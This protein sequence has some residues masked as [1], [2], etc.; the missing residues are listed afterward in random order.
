MRWFNKGSNLAV[1]MPNS[2]W[3][4][5]IKSCDKHFPNECGGILIGNY[6]EALN[7]AI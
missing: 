7:T 2:V 6:D 3:N 1:I 4:K 5:I